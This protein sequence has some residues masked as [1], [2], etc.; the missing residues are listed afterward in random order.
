LSVKEMVL[1]VIGWILAGVWL[2]GAFLTFAGVKRL[3]PLADFLDRVAPGGG[4]AA[5]GAPAISVIVT[6]R[7]E[8]ASIERTLHSLLAQR[9][10]GLEIIVIDD[11]S[12]DGTSEIADQVVAAY[13]GP[14]PITVVHNRSLPPGWLGKCHACHLGA[15]RARGTWL[16]FTD[17]DVTF[18]RP[19]LIARMLAHA[20]REALDHV[21]IFPDNRPMSALQTAMMMVFGQ[22][23]LMAARAW[24]MDRDRPAGGAG[25][26]AFNMMRRTAYERVGG[27]APLKMD[28][29]DDVKLGMLLKAAGFRQRLFEGAGWVHCAWHTGALNVLRGL[30]KNFFAGLDYSI[31]RLLA[32]TAAAALTVGG[33]LACAL[34][35][36]LTA[37]R[38]V[39][40]ILAACAWVPVL[41]QAGTVFT[42]SIIQSRRHGGDWLWVAL[43]YPLGVALVLAAAWNSA[44]HTL[45]RGGVRW[46]DTFYP[47][48][49]LRRGLVRPGRPS[50]EAR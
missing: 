11:R 2:A 28:P 30:E 40:L 16:L 39:P 49:E 4:A 27:H 37:D 1:I 42:A 7:D 34:A 8:A 19:D 46:R 5:R 6:A 45:A 14:I 23:L 43:L 12:T 21:A 26:G 32:V 36:S 25:V 22:M 24:E 10:C 35:V 9:G 15:Q 18:L 29:A 44:L 3:R 17:G 38:A 20:E 31:T 13:H 48:A 50:I 41:L 33:P 47:L